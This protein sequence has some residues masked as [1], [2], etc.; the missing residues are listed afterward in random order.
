[1]TVLSWMV[2]NVGGRT[3]PRVHGIETEGVCLEIK[4]SLRTGEA[5]A[6]VARRSDRRGRVNIMMNVRWELADRDL[7]LGIERNSRGRMSEA[8]SVAHR[9]LYTIFYHFPSAI[10][11]ST[12][13]GR[14]GKKRLKCRYRARR[15]HNRGRNRNFPPI[16]CCRGPVRSSP[17]CQISST[18]TREIELTPVYRTGP[19]RRVY[20][21][22]P[23]DILTRPHDTLTTA[24]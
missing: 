16:S 14:G 19:T 23:H 11:A 6:E 4:L 15:A 5:K 20:D 24:S 12:A 13:P 8:G 17:S 21:T 22:R 2:S 1:M 7:E 9:W 18:V 3:R 10:Q